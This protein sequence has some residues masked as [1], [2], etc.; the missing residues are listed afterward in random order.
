MEKFTAALL[1]HNTNTLKEKEINDEIHPDDFDGFK[2]DPIGFMNYDESKG[3]S[4]WAE[5]VN[6]TTGELVYR[7]KIETKEDIDRE[8]RQEMAM[9]AGMLHG[10]DAYNE[11]MGY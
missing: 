10:I 4:I 9:E 8:W 7:Q 5:I 2:E 11:V 3:D 6:T 1:I